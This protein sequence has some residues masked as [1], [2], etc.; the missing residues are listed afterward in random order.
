MDFNKIRGMIVEKYGTIQSFAKAVGTTQSQMSKY[1]NGK[2]EWS[3]TF[4]S[5]VI[6]ALGVPPDKIG[7]IFFKDT[8]VKTQ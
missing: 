4:L 2:S 6:D 8:V 1:I 5:R 3:Y 7:E